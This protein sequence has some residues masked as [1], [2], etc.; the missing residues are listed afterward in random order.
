MYS[1]EHLT[2]IHDGKPMSFSGCW[3]GCKSVKTVQG[4]A[5]SD[6]CVTVYIFNTGL[7]VDI[8]D[9]ISRD[10]GESVTIYSIERNISA[11]A[12]I[13]HICVKGA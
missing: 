5:V 2:L 8:G 4:G 11:S 12:Y 1:S 3:Q 13:N 6:D 10:T 9:R 7:P